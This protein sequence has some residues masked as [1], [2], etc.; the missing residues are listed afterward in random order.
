MTRSIVVGVDQTP[1]TPSAV[2]WAAD[3]AR[4]NHADVHVVH[5]LTYSAEFNRDLSIANFTTWRRQLRRQLEQEWVEPLR[6]AGVRFRTDLV[7][8][9]TVEDGLVDVAAKDSASLIVLGAHD[10]SQIRDRLLG[11]VV[12]KVTHKAR[13]PVVVVPV[14]APGPD[15]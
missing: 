6:A 10:H 1:A 9:D 4:D 2:S 11:N 15:A 13:C 3:Y 7:Q 5:V 8:A 12:H 14:D